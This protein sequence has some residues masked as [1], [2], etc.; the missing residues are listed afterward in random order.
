MLKVEHI[1]IA[2]KKLSVRAARLAYGGMAATVRRAAAA[3]A[4][5]AGRRWDE[6]ALQA[7]TAAL[8]TDFQPLTDLRASA[9]YRLQV[10]GHLLRRFWLET[11]AHDALPPQALS[12]WPLEERP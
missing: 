11:R 3:E 2:V 1:G 10:A 7:A 6:A 5:L 12:V 9:G 4:A 8:A